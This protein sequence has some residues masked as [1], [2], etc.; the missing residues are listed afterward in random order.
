[1]RFR[2]RTDAGRQLAALLAERQPPEPIVVLGLPRGGVPVAAPIAAA[3]QAPLEVFVARKIGA[4]GHEEFGI[5]AVAEGSE[6]VVVTADAA[7]LGITSNATQQLVARAFEELQ[8]RVQAYREGRELPDLAGRSVVLVDDGLATGVTAEA[9]V[10]SLRRQRPQ[11][12]ILAVPVCPPDTR[13]RLS[14]LADEVICLVA[15]RHFH[16][17]GQWYERFDQTTDQEVQDLLAT[18]RSAAHGGR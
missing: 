11:R 14:R 4:P 13:A 1:M 10:R 8:R 6:E 12:L 7:R 15:P 9:A 2:D 5:G 16:A 18:C 3:L 17:V